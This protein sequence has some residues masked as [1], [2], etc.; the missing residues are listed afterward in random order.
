VYCPAVNGSES[1]LYTGYQML[2]SIA[3]PSRK[4]T[5]RSRL[6]FRNTQL[7]VFFFAR[8]FFGPVACFPG[9]GMSAVGLTRSAKRI[10][11]SVDSGMWTVSPGF[12]MGFSDLF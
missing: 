12:G 10:A 5:A 11:S 8:F 3:H 4:A 2:N 9:L 1:A 7:A 6:I